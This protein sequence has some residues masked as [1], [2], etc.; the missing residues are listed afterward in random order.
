MQVR[1]SSPI[2]YRTYTRGRLTFYITDHNKIYFKTG[3]QKFVLCHNDG[4]FFSNY[5]T[6][7]KMTAITMRI[8]SGKVQDINSLWH[9]CLAEGVIWQAIDRLPL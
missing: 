5:E 8:K 7:H 1:Q 2:K 4:V 3:L 9:Y 6:S